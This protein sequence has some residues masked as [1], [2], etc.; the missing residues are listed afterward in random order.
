M[1]TAFDTAKIKTQFICYEEY[2]ESLFDLAE[3][4]ALESM[5][6]YPEMFSVAFF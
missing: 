2:Q 4:A 1:K 5:D 6:W 3:A